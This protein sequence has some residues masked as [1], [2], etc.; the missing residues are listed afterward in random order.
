MEVFTCSDTETMQAK[1]Q[2]QYEE[3]ILI[4]MKALGWMWDGQ[5]TCKGYIHFHNNQSL[6]T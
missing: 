1:T 3:K 5:V 4:K 2:G 6:E